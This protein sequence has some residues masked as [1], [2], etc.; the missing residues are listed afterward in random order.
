MLAT[1]AEIKSSRALEIADVAVGSS[2]FKTLVNEASRRLLRRGDWA[3]TVIS[4]YVCVRNGCIVWPRYVGQIRKANLCH[5][6]IPVRSV[7]YD[8]FEADAFESWKHCGWLGMDC[9]SSLVHYGRAPVHQDIKGEARYVRLYH[10]VNEDLGKTVTIFGEDN[11]GQI[12]R[13]R[14]PATGTYY[15]GVTL[16]AQLPYA[17]TP[18]YVRRI[19]RVL[20]D[21]TQGDFRL[22]AYD[23]ANAVLEDV[24]LYEPTE[25]NPAFVR[26]KLSGACGTACCSTTSPFGVAALVK[27]KYLPIINDQDLVLIQNLDALKLMMQSVRCGEGQDFASAKAYELEAV[28]ELNHEL[29]DET[30]EDQIAVNVDCFSGSGL[31]VRQMN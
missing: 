18:G 31:G 9:Q 4:V 8:Y 17:Q 20:K 19:D 1:F 11:N 14:D 29:N 15:D 6:A 25:T 10:T 22:Y 5:H 3:G 16:V 24:A 21:V 23:T 30:P 13:R 2:K 28:R 27:L 7:Y 26:Y 12:L